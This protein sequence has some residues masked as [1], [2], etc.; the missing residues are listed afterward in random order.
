MTGTIQ[1]LMMVSMNCL[2]LVIYYKQLFLLMQ[3]N[4]IPLTPH[5]TH[6]CQLV[7]LLLEFS[8]NTLCLTSTGQKII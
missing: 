8:T 6:S 3:L 4:C 1:E 5:T 2:C 7:P